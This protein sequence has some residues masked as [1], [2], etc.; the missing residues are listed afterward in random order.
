MTTPFEAF[1][2]DAA[3]TRARW[4][5]RVV[6][7]EL[8]D[9]DAGFDEAVELE[10]PVVQGEDEPLLAPPEDQV[11]VGGVEELDE[12]PEGDEVRLAETGAAGPGG[13]D[14]R[15]LGP[16]DEF[17]DDEQV[18]VLLPDR[19]R[20]HEILPGYPRQERLRGVPPAHDRF[21]FLRFVLAPGDVDRRPGHDGPDGLSEPV[22][23][24]G[25]RRRARKFPESFL[26]RFDPGGDA[27][28][29]RGRRSVVGFHVRTIS[30]PRRRPRPF[31]P[32]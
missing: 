17:L 29:E 10:D 14:H 15:D 27:F 1:V 9:L 4:C 12:D 23:E 21:E 16:V 18:L 28:D 7:V 13:D 5:G 11:L 2:S 8:R 24:I 30:T 3:L 25:D 6:V 32:C 22:R 19:A 20:A 26:E 31:R